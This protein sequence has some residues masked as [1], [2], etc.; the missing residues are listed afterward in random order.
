MQ[1]GCVCQDTQ[2]QGVLVLFSEAEGLGTGSLFVH[3]FRSC[4]FVT[5]PLLEASCWH[6]V[7]GHSTNPGIY[8]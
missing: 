7:G 5:S 6:L 2:T 8:W 1:I 3:L 4:K